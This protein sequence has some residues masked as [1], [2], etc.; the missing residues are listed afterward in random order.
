MINI[1]D[2]VHGDGYGM[3]RGKSP[4]NMRAIIIILQIVKKIANRLLHSMIIV[5]TGTP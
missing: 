3:I 1:M 2:V 5:D 4:H